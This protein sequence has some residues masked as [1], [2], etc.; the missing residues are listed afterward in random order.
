MV[1]LQ[2]IEVR[3]IL[4]VYAASA[5]PDSDPPTISIT[6]KDFRNAQEVYINE[7]SS[8][9]I[10]ITS[11]TSILAEL[12]ANMF[13]T[14]IRTITIIS[15]RLTR[16][17]RSK[18]FFRIA[19]TPLAVSGFERLIQLFLKILL[20][21]PRSDIFTNIGGALIGVLGR[22]ISKP[23]TSTLT[24]DLHIA[25]TRARQQIMSMQSGDPMISMEERLLFA[26]V[27]EAKFIPSELAL[28]GKIALGN[29]AGKSSVVGLGL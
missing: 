2:V 19:D 26:K 14:Q 18:L 11:N 17:D 29:Q 3:D 23:T 8:P 7:T 9:S 4:P 12:P 25:V 20:Q 5:I 28:I 21:T 1:D 24:S 13:G 10:I 6:G 15:S 22:K 16:M 27:I